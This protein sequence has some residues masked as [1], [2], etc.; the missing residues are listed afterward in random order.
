M[1]SWTKETSSFWGK[2]QKAISTLLDCQKY[3]SIVFNN[4]KIISKLVA[5]KELHLK[6]LQIV[7]PL[8]PTLF[9]RFRW[10]MVRKVSERFIL[11]IWPVMKEAPIIWTWKSKPK[12][13]VRKSTSHCFN[14]RSAF[15]DSIKE[16]TMCHS[17]AQN[18]PCVL[19]TRSSDSAELS[20]SVTFHLLLPALKTP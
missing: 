8:D 19:K 11:S 12:L 9:F 14:W 20:W 18:L 16:K 2:T 1:I 4:F 6:T 5:R 17:E 10:K 3:R 15:E 7:N 13:M